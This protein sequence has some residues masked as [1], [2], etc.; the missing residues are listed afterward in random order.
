MANAMGDL[1]RWPLEATK[2]NVVRSRIKLVL[3]TA[4]AVDTTNTEYPS[5]DFSVT[6]PSGTGVYDVVFPKCKKATAVAYVQK[7]AAATVIAVFGLATCDGA[8]GTWQIQT[9]KAAAANP[10]SGD[11]IVIIIDAEVR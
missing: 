5:S 8:A 7:S 1:S 9:W 11:E 10:A 3:T 6:K 2:A 4:G